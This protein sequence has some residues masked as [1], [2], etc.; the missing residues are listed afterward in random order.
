MKV[1]ILAAGF[2]KRMLPL[3]ASIP[4]PLLRAGD[5][6]L[7]VWQIIKLA[8]AGFR[9]FVINTHHLGEQIP[10]ALGDGAQYGVTIQYSAEQT[11]LETAGGIINALPLL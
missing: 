4:K 1:M 6:S 11:L 10:A 9:E 3:T 8:N 5:N 7:I 2:G